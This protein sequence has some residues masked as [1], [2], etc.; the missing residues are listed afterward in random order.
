MRTGSSI[1]AAKGAGGRQANRSPAKHADVK[2][3][4]YSLSLSPPSA[5]APSFAFPIHQC[6]ARITKLSVCLGG[7]GR[8]KEEGAAAISPN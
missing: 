1:A 3:R 2:A 4:R 8:G 5:S 7:W 6:D